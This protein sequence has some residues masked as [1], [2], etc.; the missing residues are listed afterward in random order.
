MKKLLLII[1]TV[2]FA[3]YTVL[4]TNHII[5]T[6]GMTFVPS[7]LTINLGDTVTFNNTGGAHNV[8]GTI[9]TFP[10]N[11]ESFG[12]SV[13]T[14]LWTYQFIFNKLGLYDYQCDPH[15]GI[16]MVGTIIVQNS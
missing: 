8:N 14:S 9:S 16:G 6:Q 13:S 1:F 4:S 5:N 12:N 11:Q 10:N 3:E 2:L 7:A 15:A